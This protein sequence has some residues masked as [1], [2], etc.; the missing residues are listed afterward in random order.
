MMTFIDSTGLRGYAFF[1]SI[2][3]VSELSLLKDQAG[4]TRYIHKL[5]AQVA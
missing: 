3:L 1:T 4:L 2:D 5:P